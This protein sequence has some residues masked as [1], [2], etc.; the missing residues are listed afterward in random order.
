MIGES[1][2]ARTASSPRSTRSGVNGMWVRPDAAGVE[3][4]VRD[5][6]DGGVGGHL[7]DALRAERAVAGRALEDRAVLLR[8]VRRPGHEVAAE[9]ARPVVTSRVV[10]LG[11]LEQRVRHAHPGAALDLLRHHRRG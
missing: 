7:A 8:D 6:G 4:R 9:V 5:R 11:R 1:A 3:D 2:Q 10:R